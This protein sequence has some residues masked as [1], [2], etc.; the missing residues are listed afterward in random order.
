T[1]QPTFAFPGEKPRFCSKHKAEGHVNVRHK[2]CR[3]PQCKLVPTYGM[4]GTRVPVACLEHSEGEMVD[5]KRERMRMA[6]A[7]KKA[8]VEA[9]AAA[10][11]RTMEALVEP[12]AEELAVTAVA[13]RK[14]ARAS[15]GLG[16]NRE[17]G[18]KIIDAIFTSS[19]LVLEAEGAAA[20]NDE[21]EWE[22]GSAED[23]EEEEEGEE[24]D[25]GSSMTLH[26][27]PTP[28]AA[29]LSASLPPTSALSPGV[30]PRTCPAPQAV[31]MVPDVATVGCTAQLEAVAEEERGQP[32]GERVVLPGCAGGGV[33]VSSG[34]EGGSGDG[35]G[36]GTRED[37]ST[38]RAGGERGRRSNSS[39]APSSSPSNSRCLIGGSAGEDAATVTGTSV[40]AAAVGG[41]ANT[42]SP[43]T[44]TRA[45]GAEV[46]VEAVPGRG[47]EG[48][49]ISQQQQQQQ[50]VGRQQL[51]P[52]PILEKIGIGTSL[53]WSCVRCGG[54]VPPNDRYVLVCC[55]YGVLH[56]ECTAVFVRPAIGVRPSP[57][58]K[59]SRLVG[60]C[61]QVFM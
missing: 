48:A 37:G 44:M 46:E 49:M 57:C 45:M 38:T 43:K 28:L 3:H 24:G 20:A 59:C 36:E 12:G 26:M 1:D 52:I 7:R 58:P 22:E 32:G 47:L 11:A 55:G 39:G 17:I 25:R 60:S 54:V 8:P 27:P 14:R 41:S 53:T 29:P 10:G 23:K 2:L 51:Q 16:G 40:R 18:R 50:Q 4:R 21:S 34:R 5:L 30:V 15:G 6:Q 35:G 42:S 19:Q 9:T 13:G 56:Q 33:T 61:L 31:G